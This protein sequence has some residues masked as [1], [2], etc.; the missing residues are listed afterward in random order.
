MNKHLCRAKRKDNNE[1]IYGYVCRYGHTGKEKWYIIPEYASALYVI[2]IDPKTIER[3]TGFSDKNGRIIFEGDIFKIP[4][5]I[6][7]IICFASSGQ[8]HNS[9]DVENYG[10]VGFDEDTGCYDFVKYKFNKNSVETALHKNHVIT[11]PKLVSELEIFGKIQDN[12][13]LLDIVS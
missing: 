11:F 1:W 9:S 13:N 4:D 12:P 3:C 5:E 8:E 10:V 6:W 7:T 2:E